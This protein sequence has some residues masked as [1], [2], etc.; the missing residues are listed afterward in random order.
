MRGGG[1]GNTYNLTLDS[2]SSK[3]NNFAQNLNTQ[4]SNKTKILTPSFI[5]AHADKTQS[6][7]YSPFGE[8]IPNLTNLALQHTNFSPTNTLG[9]SIQLSGT[10]W[11]IAGIIS[12]MCGVPLNMPIFGNSFSHSQFLAGLTCISDI[13]DSKGYTQIFVMG[14]DKNFAG[15]G[16]FLNTHKLAT[17]DLLYYKE[18]EKVPAN[19]H[20]NWGIEDSKLFTIAKDELE[21]LDKNK[22]F[23]MYILTTD[24][25][26]PDGF[27]DRESC[28]NL[29]TSNYQN[30]IKCSDKIISDFVE[31]IL[32]SEL[33][34][35]TTIVILGDHLSMK[36]DFFPPDS[37]RYV[38]NAF[39]N[40]NFSLPAAYDVSHNREISHFDISALLLDS[41][42]LKTESFG[43]GRN[44]LYS[45]TLL[46]TYGTDRLNELMFEDSKMYDGFWRVKK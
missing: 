32:N 45:K 39:I 28:P 44:P 43:L 41:I 23:A 37:K 21:N 3:N 1:G 34:R 25:H 7:I 26:F 12:Y 38:Y 22:P 5:D 31:S 6:K 19:Y 24:T 11:T 15:R 4:D 18:N 14:S 16:S 17:H 27:L 42:G 2:K 35:D 29:Y 8:L 36:Q 40:A 33:G 9:G 20:Q 10:G 30:A 13:L 46:E